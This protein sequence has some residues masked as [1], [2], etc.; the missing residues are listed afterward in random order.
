MP[1]GFIKARRE[2]PP[3]ALR[4][5]IY[6]QLSHARGGIYIMCRAHRPSD[7]LGYSRAR[8]GW[9]GRAGLAFGRFPPSKLRQYGR[10]PLAPLA[11]AP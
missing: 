8:L 5:G 10:A 1:R 2:S 11:L 6:I 7:A 9:G 4:G 3:I